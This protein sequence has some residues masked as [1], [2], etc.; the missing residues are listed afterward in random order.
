MNQLIKANYLLPS[1]I[2]ANINET[3][4]ARQIYTCCNHSTPGCKRFN[5]ILKKI[6]LNFNAGNIW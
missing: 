1:Y 2:K 4:C 3:L 6:K 5:A